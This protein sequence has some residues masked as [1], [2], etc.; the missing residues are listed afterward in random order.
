MLHLMMLLL[1][2]L[3]L[4]LL[5]LAVA[6]VAPI[7]IGLS[8][9]CTGLPLRSGLLR[10]G[11]AGLR[12]PLR[13]NPRSFLFGDLRGRL[14]FCRHVFGVLLHGLALG[15]CHC[16]GFLHCGRGLHQLL[17]LVHILGAFFL[18]ERNAVVAILLVLFVVGVRDLCIGAHD[19]LAIGVAQRGEPRTLQLNVSGR[20][21]TLRIPP[22]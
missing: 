14:L 9:L 1:L 8:A 4:V 18:R 13:G 3:L 19:F 2:L 20:D 16:C 17:L 7:T 12:F 11:M 6:V 22:C 15:L 10:R 5:L 21:L